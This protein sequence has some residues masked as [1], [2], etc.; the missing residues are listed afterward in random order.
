MSYLDGQFIK[1][2]GDRNLKD[3][4][5]YNF[6]LIESLFHTYVHIYILFLNI[7]A[8]LLEDKFQ[9]PSTTFIFHLFPT[10][11]KIRGGKKS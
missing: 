1:F 11:L 10:I 3:S 2:T 4:N 9:I 7:F 5:N 6:M 8:L